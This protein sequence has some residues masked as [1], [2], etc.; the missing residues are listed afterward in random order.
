MIKKVNET[1]I[2]YIEYGSGK[3]TIVFLHGWGQNIE[4]M[5][6]IATKF[7]KTNR[8]IIID[9]PGF[10]QSSEPNKI[11]TMYDYADTIYELLT[12]LKVTNPIL[13]GHSFG[14]KI[15]LIYASKYKV[16][17]LILFGSPFKKEIK[18]L[19]MKT[20]ILKFLKTVPVVNKLEGFAKKH[21]G[22]RD[23][24]AASDFMR[25]ILV[26]HVNLDITEEVKNIKCPT[27][28]VWG[29][30]D[31]EV[32]IERAYELEELISD[33]AVI[34]YEGCSHYA[35]LERK[36]QTINIIKNFIGGNE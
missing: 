34:P 6:P 24:K 31:Q 25:K 27:I 29:T 13:V 32:P 23:Y 22:S 17:K 30:M 26:E 7:K 3:D 10:G 19:S 15:S 35:Y 1:D 9:L 21:I 36:A 16:N 11:W 4:M 14:G 20:K 18:K 12:K 2:N 8:V 5:E 33:A 28:L